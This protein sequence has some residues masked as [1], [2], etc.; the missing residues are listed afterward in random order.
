MQDVTSSIENLIEVTNKLF[1]LLPNT[2]ANIGDQSQRD[3]ILLKM[4]TNQKI[5][6]IIDTEYEIQEKLKQLSRQAYK[7]PEVEKSLGG[8]YER[9]KVVME[10]VTKILMKISSLEET[11]NLSLIKEQIIDDFGQEFDDFKLEIRNNLSKNDFKFNNVDTN[12]EYLASKLSK[13]ELEIEKLGKES[14]SSCEKINEINSMV[15]GLT[16]YKLK[17]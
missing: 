2:I 5:N 13:L 1:A 14:R 15:S 12:I 16:I 4:R 3:L 7:L 8:A 6:E 17:K 11:L 10:N 9:L